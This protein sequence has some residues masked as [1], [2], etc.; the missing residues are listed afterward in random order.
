MNTLT[1]IN[2]GHIVL[3]LPF[4][5]W[6]GIARGNVPNEV[7]QSLIY[8]GAFVMIYQGY[9]AYSGWIQNSQYLWINLLH[10]VYIGPLLVYIGIYKKE[11]PKNIYDMLLL[12]TFGGFGYHL[13]GLASRLD[14]L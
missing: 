2:L 11:T 4:L 12:L 8:I 14:F 13:Y 1:L 7:F 5:L 10:V 3:I 6:V 9:K